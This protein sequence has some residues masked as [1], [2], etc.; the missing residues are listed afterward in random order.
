MGGAGALSRTRREHLAHDVPKAGTADLMVRQQAA[1]LNH[2]KDSIR[3]RRILRIRSRFQLYDARFDAELILCHTGDLPG[4][5]R[6]VR[7]LV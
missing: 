5:L 2:G 3:R 6:D 4:E 7:A 1:I